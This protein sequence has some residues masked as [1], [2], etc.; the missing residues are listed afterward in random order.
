MG[1]NMTLGFAITAFNAMQ[2]GELTL[3][4][5]VFD[6]SGPVPEIELADRCCRGR[7]CRRGNRGD[8]P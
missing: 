6:T 4:K 2:Q 8:Q 5:L 1:L 3:D 7:G